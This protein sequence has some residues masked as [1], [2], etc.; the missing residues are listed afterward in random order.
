VVEARRRWTDKA[1]GA[2][3]QEDLRVALDGF[4]AAQAEKVECD[5][6]IAELRA[7]VA[8]LEVRPCAF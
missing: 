8:S 5:K 6:T 3:A 7:R 4:E 1:R 2:A